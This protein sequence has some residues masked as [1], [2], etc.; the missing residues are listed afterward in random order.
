MSLKL[1]PSAFRSCVSQGAPSLALGSLA[2]L[3]LVT[4]LLVTALW[5]SPMAAASQAPA[6]EEQGV[7]DTPLT[8]SQVSAA[9]VTPADGPV[10]VDQAKAWGLDFTHFA[11]SSGRLFFP[12][13]M[14]GA[15]ALGDFDGDQDLDVFL[16]QG[17][18]LG[19][20]L[21][22]NPVQLEEA[23]P[24]AP[25]GHELGDRLFLNQLISESSDSESPDSGSPDSGSPAAGSPRFVDST[26]AAGLKGSG[27]SSEGYGMGVATGDY[28]NDGDLDL[29]VARLGKN[30]LLR[31]R[32]DATFEEVADLSGAQDD[33]WSV[34]ATFVDYDQDGWLDLFVVNYGVY[35]VESDVRCFSTSSRRDYCGPSAYP[36]QSDRLF[37][38]RGDGTFENV[39]LP[40]GLSKARGSGLGVSSA[41]F[42]GDGRPDLFVANDG[43]E[44]FLWINGGDGQFE[45]L[46]LL[47]GVALSRQGKPEASMGVAVGDVDSD[48]DPDLLLTHLASETNTLYRNEGSGL[49]TDVSVES[50]LGGPSLAK[51]AF[52]TA[53][54]D[55]DNDGLLDLAV[56]NGAVKTDEAQAAAGAGLPLAQ[57]DQ[58][59]HNVGSGRFAEV[60][61][62]RAGA[63]LSR[64]GVGR[65]LAVG[66]FDND[67]DADLLLADCGA[68]TRLLVNQVGAS[69]RWVGFRVVESSV[70]GGGFR[71]AFGAL[72]EVEGA[73]GPRQVRRV[74]TDGS[75]ASAS[76]PRVL[77]GLASTPADRSVAVRVT[78]PDG[79][80]ERFP[81]LSLDRYHELRRGGGVAIAAEGDAK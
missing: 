9:A 68:A 14:G 65:G 11:G 35:S 23:N 59:F 16:V 71:D 7:S 70:E 20:D 52:G 78:W 33:R 79:S 32:G 28:D 49:F 54:I 77:F 27:T 55:Y 61:A 76:D 47:S 73:E 42:D 43:E 44:N 15:V 69:S 64:S 13:M 67:G 6:M 19:K 21:A 53:W 62:E 25:P 72:V 75:Y 5:V 2:F 56:A 29:Y 40:A 48:G 81:S 24:P 22:E 1:S 74:A 4:V 63:D 3:L 38:N 57:P 34:I 80:A 17:H 18:L 10:F 60:P 39:S 26:V 51:T 50:G 45:D 36:A 37:R 41:D 12:E 8:E 31:N 46:G 66:D 30:S 58:L